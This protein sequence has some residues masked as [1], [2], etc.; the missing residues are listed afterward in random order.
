MLRSFFILSLLVAFFSVFEKVP[1]NPIKLRAQLTNTATTT[2]LADVILE[3]EEDRSVDVVSSHFDFIPSLPSISPT[4][5]FSI[6]SKV[7]GSRTFYIK[8]LFL[9]GPPVLAKIA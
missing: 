3:Q 8:H 7:Q 2:T 5:F 4:A 1:A 6:P 9:R